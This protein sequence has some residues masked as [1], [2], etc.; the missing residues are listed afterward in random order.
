MK[1]LPT[2]KK[3]R[4]DGYDY[5]RNGV[6]F[7]TVCVQHKHEI[8]GLVV[9]GAN[10]VRPSEV[11]LS[12][13]GMVVDTAIRKIGEIYQDVHVDKY[14]IMPNHIHMILAIDNTD[15]RTMC[16]PTVSRIVKHCKEYVTK[17]IGFSVWQK[18]Y[19]DHIIR[20][21]EEYHA[22]WRYMD[23]NPAKWPEDDYFIKSDSQ[24]IFI[25]VR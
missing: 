6:Y 12:D 15:G 25:K 21:E 18:S 17:Q 22:I 4:L 5:S 19:H 7:I 14:V 3:I 9:V 24:L 16:A 11:A 10:M 1:E 13:I 8:L 2:R 20:D 23:E